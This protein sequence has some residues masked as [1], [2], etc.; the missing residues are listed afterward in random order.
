MKRIL[1]VNVNW[2]GDVLFSTPLIRAIRKRYPDSFM[3][4]LLVPRCVSILKHNP[5]LDKIIIFDE[6]GEH[7]S[8][9]GK[10][11]LVKNLRT[12]NFD[13][14]FLL[15]R[16]FTRTLICW[17]AGIPERIGYYTRKRAA[18]LTKSIQPPAKPVH[19]VEY[20]LHI[21]KS[22]GIEPE[23]KGYEFFTSSEDKNYVDNIFREK[24]LNQ[25]DFLVAINPGGNWVLKR[26][27]KNN[28]AYLADRL[29]EDYNAKVI[30]TG[31]Q[32]DIYLAQDIATVMKNAPIILCGKTTLGQLAVLMG[33]VSLVIS[34]D[35]G[36][37][38]IAVSQKAKVIGLFGPT[39]AQITGPYGKG[40]YIIIQK[41]TKCEIPCY[42]LN[43]E[44][45]RCMEAIT[46]EDVLEAV[47]RL[48]P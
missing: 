10:L 40:S 9:R 16:S 12:D 45:A 6:D 30:I 23:N 42:R 37:M 41:N 32:D 22:V 8:M 46:V 3:A 21:A 2:R 28:F 48:C 24:G 19:K 5:Y 18:L 31:A 43:C 17:L 39:C 13:I 33:K 20:F 27:P 36:P 29:I 47:K 34:N 38:H 15:H 14:A 35:S 44:D 11:Q 26:W 25:S 4:T 7:K 1:I